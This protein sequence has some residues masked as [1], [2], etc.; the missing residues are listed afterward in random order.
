MGYILAKIIKNCR[1]RSRVIINYFYFRQ[2]LNTENVK[3]SAITFFAKVNA[4][5]Y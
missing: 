5:I 3:K 1:F 2:L 4:L